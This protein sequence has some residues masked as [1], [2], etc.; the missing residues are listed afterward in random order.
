MRLTKEKK[1]KG[2]RSRHSKIIFIMMMFF[3][4]TPCLPLQGF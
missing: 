1:E 2:R 4:S 3:V